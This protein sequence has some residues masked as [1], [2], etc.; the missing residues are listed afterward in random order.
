MDIHDVVSLAELAESWRAEQPDL[1]V[2]DPG[3]PEE[4]L[5]R[6]GELLV[7]SDAVPAAVDR[8]RRWVDRV[9]GTEEPAF[10]RIR[11]RPGEQPVRIAADC[12]LDVAPNHVHVGSPIMIGTARP[13]PEPADAP[14]TPADEA[15]DV[16]VAVLDTGLDPHPWFAGR[17][18]FRAV[19]EVLDADG[20]PGQDRQAGHGTFVAGVL[21]QHAPGV[22]LRPRRVLSSLGLTDDLTVARGL[23]A[24]RGADVVL[25]T[26]GCHTADDR[27]PPVLRHEVRQPG[28][29]VVAAA[30]NGGTSRPVWPAALPEVVA[31]GADAE[32]SN[33]GEWVDVIAP[34]VGVASSFVRLGA[35]GDGGVRREYGFARWSGTSFAAPH[36]AAGV[37][38]LLHGGASPADAVRQVGQERGAG[39]EFVVGA[40]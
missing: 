8:L 31:V 4:C 15:W 26:A 40:G 5:L 13:L 19:P 10:A 39:E 7:R 1:T 37:A 12:G 29:V 16:T 21:L 18:W 28:G 3:G 24:V 33:H 17:S 32:F 14:P 25:L 27:C 36:A 20:R 30:G 9:D 22:R 38:R 11:L 23:R 34:G 35:G 6:S 2:H